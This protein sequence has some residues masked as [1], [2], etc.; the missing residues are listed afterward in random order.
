MS[1]HKCMC[2]SYIYTVNSYVNTI[3]Y[4]WT[5]LFNYYQFIHVHL[6]KTG[7]QTL[8]FQTKG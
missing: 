5:F 3:K 1:N 8:G 4:C 7:K 2:I 6:Q